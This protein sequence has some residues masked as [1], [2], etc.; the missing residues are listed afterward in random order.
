VSGRYVAARSRGL[1]S[2]H[3]GENWLM[4][5]GPAEQMGTIECESAEAAINLTSASRAS[6]S[7]AVTAITKR[8]IVLN[9]P[10]SL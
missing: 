10:S 8:S 7:A 9:G 2:G 3:D 1:N 4:R 6:T 5:C